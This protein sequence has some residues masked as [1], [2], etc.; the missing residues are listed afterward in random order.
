MKVTKHVLHKQMT[1]GILRQT[2]QGRVSIQNVHAKVDGAEKERIYV[3]LIFDDG[4]AAHKS[5]DGRP[6]K[7]RGICTGKREKQIGKTIT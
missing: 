1:V 6:I 2:G 7:V 3:H 4:H 5:E